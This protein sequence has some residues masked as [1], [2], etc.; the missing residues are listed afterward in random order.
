MI[1]NLL[2]LSLLILHNPSLI[3]CFNTKP[4]RVTITKPPPI[5]TCKTNAEVRRAIDIYIN[6]NDRILELGSQL[7]DTSTYLCQAISTDDN[8]TAV[9]VDVKRKETTSGR[10]KGRDL[11]ILQSFANR[12][13]YHELEQFEQWKELIKQPKQFDGLILDVGSP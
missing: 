6:P 10:S 1:P 2:H 4:S 8:G 5:I 13:E 9:L 11:S 7:S 12:I 3:S